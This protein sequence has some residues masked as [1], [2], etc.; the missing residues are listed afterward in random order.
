MSKNRR[1]ALVAAAITAAVVAFVL[2]RP[3]DEDEDPPRPVATEAGPAPAPKPEPKPRPAVV[4]L[5]VRGGQPVGGVEKI[6]VNKGDTVRLRVS[7]PDTSD[8]VHVHGYDLRKD[9]AP[10]RPVSFRFRARIEGVFEV[11][12]EGSHTQIASLVVEPS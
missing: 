12:L 6:E 9:M 5:R 10:G 3:A 11:E 1:L 4:R 2:I 7:S 8:E